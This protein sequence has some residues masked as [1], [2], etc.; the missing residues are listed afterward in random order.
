MSRLAVLL[1]WLGCYPKVNITANM[2]WLWRVYHTR[3]VSALVVVRA[4][5]TVHQQDRVIIV[6]DPIRR[7]LSLAPKRIQYMYD[8]LCAS[9]VRLPLQR[10]AG[11]CYCTETQL[12][13][14]CCTTCQDS[15]QGVRTLSNDLKTGL[16]KHGTW[17]STN[18]TVTWSVVKL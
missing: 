4:R 5:I 12:T 17:A 2:G 8:T 7:S 14:V 3:S 9:G 1:F 10:Q 18:G 11:G 13:A 16:R 6:S 15:R